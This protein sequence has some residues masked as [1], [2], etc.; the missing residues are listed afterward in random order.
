MLQTSNFRLWI[1]LE[2][3]E[4]QAPWIFSF[5]SSTFSK[6]TPLIESSLAHA[7]PSAP[8]AASKIC[9][10][11]WMRD[12]TDSME[13]NWDWGL[14]YWDA[15]L[16]CHDEGLI[17]NFMRHVWVLMGLSILQHVLS[18]LDLS[19]SLHVAIVKSKNAQI[20]HGTMQLI[21]K[22]QEWKHG[23]VVLFQRQRPPAPAHVHQARHLLQCAQ[24][25]RTW[26]NQAA[27]SF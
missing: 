6:N 21:N 24:N 8:E 18:A 12:S 15:F 14:L 1:R 16:Q 7:L 10:P 4:C 25:G 20:K 23:I 13:A 17:W 9:P 19:W 5:I 11:Y 26:E 3:L 27:N 22:R 2:G